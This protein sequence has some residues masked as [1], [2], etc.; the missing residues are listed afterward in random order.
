MKKILFGLITF[1]FFMLHSCSKDDGGGDP[2][3]SITTITEINP[4][5]VGYPLAFKCEANTQDD[6][7]TSAKFFVDGVQINGNSFTPSATGTISVYSTYVKSDGTTL[8]SATIQIPVQNSLRFNK[9]VLIEDYT[10]TWCGFCPRVA[11]AINLV[12]AETSDVV[13]VA[14]HRTDGSSVD[15]YHFEAATAVKNFLGFSGYPQGYLNRNIK[16]NSPEVGYISQA[17]DLTKGVNPYLGVAIENSITGNTAS[18]TVKVKFGRN[19]SNVKLVVYLL[20][21][22]LIHDQENY[23]TYFGG[24][25]VISNFQHDHVVR[26]ILTANILGDN[27]TGGTN[28]NDE[29]TKSFN[30]TIPSSV[31]VGNVEFVA[32]VLDATGRAINSRAVGPNVNQ[33]Y[34][35]E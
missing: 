15:P 31:N 33:V 16:W 3:S 8:T 25:S 17:T 23:T 7:T 27:I 2:I 24:T 21:N 19:F 9:R 18:V 10:G 5:D 32:F 30:Y 26:D 28:Y 6:L 13:P 4:A 22:G 20:E 29:Y 14:V 1:A 35:S 34:E 12:K 11:H